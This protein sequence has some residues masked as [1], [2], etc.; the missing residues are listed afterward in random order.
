MRAHLLRHGLGA[1]LEVDRVAA[2]LAHLR[3]AIG[4]H[5]TRHAAHERL[6]LREDRLE[7]AVEAARRL[8]RQFDVRQLVLA[9]RHE[10]RARQEDVR[11]LHHRVDVERHGHR[12]ALSSSRPRDSRSPPSRP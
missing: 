2:R 7:L 9:H 8:A 1:V 6:R 5:E 11:D 12:L 4:A 3:V 10:M